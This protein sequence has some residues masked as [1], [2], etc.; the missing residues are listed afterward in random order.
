[1]GK[2]A[3]IFQA[4]TCTKIANVDAAGISAKVTRITLSA[5]SPCQRLPASRGI[6]MECQTSAEAIV[7]WSHHLK[8]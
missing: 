2:K 7:S 4:R 3:I 1:M 5:L 8:G 6:R